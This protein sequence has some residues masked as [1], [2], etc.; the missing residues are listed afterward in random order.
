MFAVYFPEDS[1]EVFCIKANF[2]HL[3]A[4]VTRLNVGVLERIPLPSAFH[5]CP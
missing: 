4:V 1:T 2:K 5:A 3:R